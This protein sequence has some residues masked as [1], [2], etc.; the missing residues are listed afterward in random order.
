MATLWRGWLPSGQVET[1]DLVLYLVDRVVG[2]AA[3]NAAG[4]KGK[5]A[6]LTE[7]ASW[8]YQRG[9]FW[10]LFYPT[11]DGLNG[12]IAAGQQA[13]KGRQLVRGRRALVATGRPCSSTSGPSTSDT[14]GQAGRAML[15]VHCPRP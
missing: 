12:D 2:Q 14:P 8:G 3:T 6:G 15:H 7:S 9:S 4:K 13:K 10:C 5:T 11:L 1:F